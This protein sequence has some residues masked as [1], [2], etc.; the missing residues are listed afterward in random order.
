MEEFEKRSRLPALKHVCRSGTGLKFA[1]VSDSRV[2]RTLSHSFLTGH[3]QSVME[4]QDKGAMV[5][6]LPV[7]EGGWRLVQRRRGES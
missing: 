3:I 4:G 6:L 7:E 2:S 1:T 5:R